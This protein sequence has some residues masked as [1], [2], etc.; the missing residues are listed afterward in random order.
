LS[1][2][3]YFQQNAPT[4]LQPDP[5]STTAI[6]GLGAHV[7]LHSTLGFVEVSAKDAHVRGIGT[8]HL[9]HFEGIYFR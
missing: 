4:W 7:E 3:T 6:L 2:R 1:A 5:F 8:D 9:A